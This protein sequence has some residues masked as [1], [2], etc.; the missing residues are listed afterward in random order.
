MWWRRNLDHAVDNV[1]GRAFAPVRA[2]AQRLV[3]ALPLGEGGA[4]GVAACRPSQGEVEGEGEV[5]VGVGH[6]LDEVGASATHLLLPS[7]HYCAVVDADDEDGVDP[8]LLKPAVDL[9]RL[10][11]RDLARRSGGREGAG[12]SD[13]ED[14][15]VLEER[16]HRLRCRRRVPREADVH[17][18]VG[19]NGVSDLD[20]SRLVLRVA[21]DRC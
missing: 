13:E 2:V 12:Q 16:P 8:R 7:C 15:A 6:K 4:A 20:H 1:Q 21:E 11:A 9:S 10:E 3:W 17:D 14:L 18:D 19:R 5:S